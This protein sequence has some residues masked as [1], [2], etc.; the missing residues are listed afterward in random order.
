MHP[1]H[2]ISSSSVQEQHH[3]L[4]S[5]RPTSSCSC[6]TSSCYTVLHRSLTALSSSPHTVLFLHPSQRPIHH[7]SVVTTST[8]FCI[9][10]IKSLI[11]PSIPPLLALHILS[12]PLLPILPFPSHTHPIPLHPGPF[13]PHQP[14]Q[15]AAAVA[16]T[17]SAPRRAA[18]DGSACPFGAALAI[19]RQRPLIQHRR[20]RRH[21]IAGSRAAR[22]IAS[23]D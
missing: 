9:L 16:R 2:T 1:Q 13:S 21:S 20:S 11:T 6:H 22:S 17:G 15:D 19:C 4:L 18:P 10:P 3:A 7:P 8:H 14:G 5:H 12:F 23:I